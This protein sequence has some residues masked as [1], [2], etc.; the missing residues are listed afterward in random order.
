MK[1]SSP[2]ILLCNGADL[3]KQWGQFDCLTL[4]YREFTDGIQNI[5]LALLGFVRDVFHL[6]DRILDLG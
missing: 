4:E 6:P 5:K 2:Q 1:S 3:P